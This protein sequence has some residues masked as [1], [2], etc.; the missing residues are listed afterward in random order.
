[1]NG[2]SA[3]SRGVFCSCGEI[4]TSVGPFEIFF[5]ERKSLWI[6]FDG[7]DETLEAHDFSRQGGP[8]ARAQADLKKAMALIQAER[9]VKQRIAVGTGDGRLAAWQGQ[10]NFEISVV[11]V[12]RRDEIFPMNLQQGFP[13]PSRLEVSVPE[14]PLNFRESLLFQFLPAFGGR[15][16]RWDD[17]AVHSCLAQVL[18]RQ[19]GGPMRSGKDEDMVKKCP[20]SYLKRFG[21]TF[22]LPFEISINLD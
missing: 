16:P 11:P 13:N 17:P 10:R 12:L 2:L 21:L 18:D 6:D 14:K 4:T 22:L 9:L 19:V 5:A 8:I 15:L 20:G 1:M 7:H 3:L